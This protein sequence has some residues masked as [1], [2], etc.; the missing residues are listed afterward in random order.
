MIQQSAQAVDD[1]EAQSQSVALP[2]PDRFD[3]IE[4]AE[5]VALLILRNTDSAVADVDAQAVSGAPAAD[6]D[7]AG[8]CVTDR[9]GDKIEQDAFEQN[10]IAENT[11][12][13][14]QHA[15]VESLL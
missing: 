2:A 12:P 10:G 1:G 5:D 6:D 9:V 7:T 3:L 4:F 15:Q 11:E 8:R 13:A 14:R